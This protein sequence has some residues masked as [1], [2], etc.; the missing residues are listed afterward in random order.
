MLI[1]D[2]SIF[3]SI[4]LILLCFSP[5]IMCMLTFNCAVDLNASLIPAVLRVVKPI[6]KRWLST[7]S[8]K[9]NRA[10]NSYIFIL[11]FFK[12]FCCTALNLQW[13]AR[14]HF[15]IYYAQ[16]LRTLVFNVFLWYIVCI[17]LTHLLV[18]CEVLNLGNISPFTTV[19]KCCCVV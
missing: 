2:H 8:W 5:A 1:L 13:Q 12:S 14:N 10:P 9:D 16:M 7:T 19:D 6:Y 11:F 3:K 4:L 17:C 15:C 18:Q